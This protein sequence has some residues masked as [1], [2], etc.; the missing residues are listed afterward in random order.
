M[1]PET[2]AIKA[3]FKY[4]TAG[5]GQECEDEA[6]KALMGNLKSAFCWNMCGMIQKMNKKPAVAANSFL[7]CLKHDPGNQRVKREATDLFLYSKDFEKHLEYRKAML[8]ENAAGLTNWNGFIIANFL[9]AS[10][11]RERRL[12]GS[13]RSCRQYSR[14]RGKQGKEKQGRKTNFEPATEKRVQSAQGRIAVLAW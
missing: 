11:D 12:W 8:L 9:V 3:L 2:K 6:K 4:Y 10:S 1:T 14:D 13:S 5:N 7:Q